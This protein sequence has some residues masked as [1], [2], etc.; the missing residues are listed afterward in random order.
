MRFYS[1]PEAGPQD[2][3][4]VGFGL[5]EGFG[6]LRGGFLGDW[7]GILKFGVL[8]SRLLGPDSGW[9]EVQ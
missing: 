7:V 2:F 1:G 3:G 8:G 5:R 9:R 4:L 6:G